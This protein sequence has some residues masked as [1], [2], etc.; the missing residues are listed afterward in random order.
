MIRRGAL[1]FFY[2]YSFMIAALGLKNNLWGTGQTDLAIETA[3]HNLVRLD[4]VGT[5]HAD[6][7]PVIQKLESPL[8]LLLAVP[9]SSYSLFCHC[10]FWECSFKFVYSKLSSLLSSRS[11]HCL[12]CLHTLQLLG[13]KPSVVFCYSC[14]GFSFCIKEISFPL[15]LPFPVSFSPY[16]S[17][18]DKASQLSSSSRRA[19]IRCQGSVLLRM[20]E[21]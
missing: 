18:S 1:H 2:L 3:N 4:T 10:C 14:V 19:V 12:L 20:L 5:K 16:S 21:V 17:L 6:I 9:F 11:L 8:L 13:E 7:G 15:S